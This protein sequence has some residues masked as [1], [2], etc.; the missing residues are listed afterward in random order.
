MLPQR[1]GGTK[2]F[3]SIGTFP[4]APSLRNFFAL[5][6]FIKS[7]VISS[8]KYPQS[9]GTKNR[10]ILSSGPEVHLIRDCGCFLATSE[11]PFISV[12]VAKKFHNDGG[13]VYVNRRRISPL[14]KP[15]F[16]S[17]CLCGK[18]AFESVMN[19]FLWQN[20]V[21]QND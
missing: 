11:L 6:C 8:K 3:C 21:V 10:K 12:E 9:P 15:F 14:L 2:V 20:I 13:A 18:N 19:L 17:L 7:P 1:Y 4:K 16:V 5:N